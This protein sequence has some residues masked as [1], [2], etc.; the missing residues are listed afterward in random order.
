MNTM[1]TIDDSNSFIFP[2]NSEYSAVDFLRKQETCVEKILW[3][4]LRFI[5]TTPFL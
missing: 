3:K 4:K 5:F 1:N 2:Y